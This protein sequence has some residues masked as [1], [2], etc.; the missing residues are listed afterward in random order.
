[1]TRLIALALLAAAAGFF[2]PDVAHSGTLVCTI[3]RL[4][5]VARPAEPALQRVHVKCV[6]SILD[7]RTGARIFYFALPATDP[8]V[9]RLLEV[10]SA[11]LAANRQLEISFTDGDTSGASFGCN[12]VDC[13]KPILIETR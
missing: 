3:D 5:V 4:A 11:A 7:S 8:N 1:M 6:N 2:G 9:N 10:G 13:R 12:A